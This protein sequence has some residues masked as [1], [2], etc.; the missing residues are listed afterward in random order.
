MLIDINFIVR[1]I[2]AQETWKKVKVINH[3]KFNMHHDL[4]T[5][6]QDTELSEN[7]YWILNRYQRG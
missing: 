7:Q 4:G 6:F 2:K 5:L 3:C 1:E